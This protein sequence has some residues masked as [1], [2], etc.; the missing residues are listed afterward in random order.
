MADLDGAR[1][2]TDLLE[3]ILDRLGPPDGHPRGLTPEE[4]RAL[5]VGP[6]CGIEQSE[7]DFGLIQHHDQQRLPPDSDG[8][9]GEQLHAVLAIRNQLILKVWQQLRADLGRRKQLIANGKEAFEYG[10]PLFTYKLEQ[11]YQARLDQAV[12]EVCAKAQDACNAV[13]SRTP[14]QAL[15][16]EQADELLNSVFAVNANPSSELRW[17]LAAATNRQYKQINS[18]FCPDPV[19]PGWPPPP[20]PLTTAHRSRHPSTPSPTAKPGSVTSAR[21]PGRRTRG[22]T[23]RACRGTP[24]QC[25]SPLSSEPPGR[26]LPVTQ[27]GADLHRT[28]HRR[29]S[30]TGPRQMP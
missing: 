25:P 4:L 27:S 21:D 29:S 15:T 2:A 11:Y 8:G 26:T 9:V 18:A 30:P 3:N 20:L 17:K 23:R 16:K 28:P 6:S 5:G 22:K 10:N 13:L 12:A 1:R 7:Y 24:L 14:A 19:P